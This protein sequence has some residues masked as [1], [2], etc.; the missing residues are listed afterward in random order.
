MIAI[1]YDFALLI[2]KALFLLFVRK[3]KQKLLILTKTRVKT[4]YFHPVH[5]E[6]NV[7]GT[8]WSVIPKVMKYI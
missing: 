3:D 5:M 2:A 7:T 1:N 6:A 4:P 8:L